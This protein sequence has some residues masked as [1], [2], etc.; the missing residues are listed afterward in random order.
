M[1]PLSSCLDL[2]KLYSSMVRH[3][4]DNF[5]RGGKRGAGSAPRQMPPEPSGSVSDIAKHPEFK[6][7]CWDFNHCDPKRCSGK[8]LIKL[9]YMRELHIGQ[10]FQGLVISCVPWSHATCFVWKMT[11]T[12][13]RPKAKHVLSPADKELLQQQGAA[14]VECSWARLKEIPFGRIGGRCERICTPVW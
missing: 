2:G 8:R 12:A 6:A 13:D 7:A 11:L 14:V 10:R 5:R 4:K 1:L 9:G 3:K